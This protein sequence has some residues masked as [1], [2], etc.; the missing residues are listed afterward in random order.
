VFRRLRTRISVLYASLFGAALLLVALA[1]Y[2]AA[3]GNAEESVRGELVASGT[4]FD[5]VWAL[6]SRQ[7]EDGASV[8]ARD[9]G[10]RESLATGDSATIGSAIENLKERLGADLAF[11]VTVD[12]EAAGM[13]DRPTADAARSLASTL[14]GGE[15]GVLVINGT[16]YQAIASPVMAPTLI[17]W[18]VF[19][20]RLDAREMEA[21]E[22]LSAIPLDAAVFHREG[23]RWR[24]QTGGAGGPALDALID[25]SLNAR[26]G[27]RAVRSDDGR[28]MALVK[29]LPGFRPGEQSVLLLR[30]SMAD[31]MAPYRGLLQTI[32]AT[33]VLG[34]LLVVAGSWGLARGITRPIS[35]LDSA[36]QRLSQGETAHVEVKG[37]DELARL[38]ASFNAMAGQIQAREEHIMHLALHDAD[39]DLPNRLA[40]EQAIEGLAAHADGKLVALVAIGVDR[41]SQVRGA[42][43]HQLS[44]ALVGALGAR[45]VEHGR[46]VAQLATDVLGLAY[47]AGD[48]ED[49]RRIAA[50]VLAAAEAPLKLDG[51]VIDVALTA[52]VAGYAPHGARVTS[53]VERASLALDQARRAHRKLAVFDE[54]AYGDPAA[55][56]SLMSDML[57]ALGDGGVEIHYQPKYDLRQGKVVGVEALVRWNHPTRGIMNPDA[58]IP[59]AEETGAI[60]ALTDHVLGRAIADQHALARQGH[61]LAM[62]INISGRLLGDLEFAEGAVALASQADGDLVFEITETAVI[63]NPDLA[64]AI[65]G[66]LTAAGIGVSIDDYGS[67]LSS[68]AY[69]KR[70]PAHELKIDKAFILDM[71]HSQRDALLVRST[72]DLA[73]SLGLKVTAEGVETPVAASL[74]AGMGCDLAQ[75]YLIARPMPFEQLLGFLEQA[76]EIGVF[77]TDRRRA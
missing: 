70:I 72:I 24:S 18:V 5:R 25:K 57:A 23:G 75:G 15:S 7:L 10:F 73:H 43:G 48:I 12:G 62:S 1:V 6:R 14:E 34:L 30:Y 29:P 8:L 54:A 27:R 68:L 49:A 55:N 16:P 50:E 28:H 2:T 63:E 71:A 53:L 56:L 33:A 21:L 65:I 76:P 22:R 19:A 46:A 66:K 40:L 64:M 17:G 52:G 60:R 38:A 13:V 31:A 67:G 9:F 69:L 39:T 59:M 58:F 77:D 3:A 36:V 26:S 32:A 37:D 44:S 20:V 41:F 51:T 35:A 42:I 4:V 11:I 74:L 61:V 47:V 45:L